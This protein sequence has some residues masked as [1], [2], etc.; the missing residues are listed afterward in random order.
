MV[1]H[2]RR[3]VGPSEASKD[4]G[5]LSDLLFAWLC[6]VQIV[7]HD[8]ATLALVGTHLGLVQVHIAGGVDA[9]VVHAQSEHMTRAIMIDDLLRF[10]YVTH[11]SCWFCRDRLFQRLVAAVGRFL[12]CSLEIVVVKRSYWWLGGG[13]AVEGLVDRLL[14]FV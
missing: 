8:V 9:V 5:S 6:R 7:L 4:L 10:E 12:S 3:R 2:L 1:V 14:S 13:V 11:V